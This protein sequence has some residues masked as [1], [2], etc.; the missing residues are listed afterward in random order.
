MARISE[1][2]VVEAGTTEEVTNS[3]V[4]GKFTIQ[5]LGGFEFRLIGGPTSTTPSDAVFEGALKLPGGEGII[6]LLLDDIW[7]D[8]G[9]NR[10][11]VRAG[12]HRVFLTVTHG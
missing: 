8:A 1:P 4:T 10:V 9:Y 3:D 5:N 6:G 2:M 11:F 12:A 7:P